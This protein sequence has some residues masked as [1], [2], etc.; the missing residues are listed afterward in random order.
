MKNKIK[1]EAF[2]FVPILKTEDGW[3]FLLIKNTPVSPEQEGHWSFPKGHKEK[4]ESDL[5]VAK[6]ELWEETGISKIQSYEKYKFYEEYIFKDRDDQIIDKRVTYFLC[7][8][9]EADVKIQEDEI[10][11]YRWALYEDALDIATYDNAKNVIKQ[12]YHILNSNFKHY[13]EKEKD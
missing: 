1:D 11:D 4:G 13:G 7:F 2:G 12:S 8:V 3:K 10:I 6:R 5:E 9:L